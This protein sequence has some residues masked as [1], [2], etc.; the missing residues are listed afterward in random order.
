MS[1][2]MTRTNTFYGICFDYAQFAWNDINKYQKAYNDAGM[3]GQEWYIAVA[4]HGDPYTI[5]LYDPVPEEQSTRMWNGIYVKEHSRHKVT[6]HD[7][8]SG[9]AWLWVQHKNGAWYWIDPTLTDNSGYVWWGI[10][11]NGRE[12]QYYPDPVYCV[13][14][15][16]P[17]H[18]ITKTETLSRDSTYTD[19]PNAGSSFDTTAVI[20]GFSTLFDLDVGSK[21]GFSLS[22]EK[23]YLKRPV[24]FFYSAFMDYGYSYRKNSGI[25]WLLYHRGFV[26]FWYRDGRSPIFLVHCVC[27]R[28]LGHCLHA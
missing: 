1:G 12:V 18:G 22:W 16:Y 17:K 8:T 6:T 25:R 28:R 11:E 14:S 23:V 7:K 21:W 13:A 5:I 24:D 20:M 19:A 27:R 10:V 3:K 4:D 9:H 15:I 26:G 2:A